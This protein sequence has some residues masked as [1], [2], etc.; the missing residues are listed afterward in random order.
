[1]LRA[2]WVSRHLHRRAESRLRRTS[3]KDRWRV[4]RRPGKA[5][6]SHGRFSA[7]C[8]DCGIVAA[9][10][11]CKEHLGIVLR[12][13]I[14]LRRAVELIDAGDKVS[15][16][17]GERNRPLRLRQNNIGQLATDLSQVSV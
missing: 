11:V 7:R 6:W 9:V 8:A 2:S 5:G 4:R 10:A 13:V 12:G 3:W 1:M 14:K 15:G 16:E 17:A